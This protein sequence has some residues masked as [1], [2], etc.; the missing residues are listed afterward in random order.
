MVTVPDII[1]GRL[2]CCSKRSSANRCI[3]AI[4]VQRLSNEKDSRVITHWEGV[5][6]FH[7]NAQRTVHLGREKAKEE[8]G[9]PDLV[10]PFVERRVA[11]NINE[12]SHGQALSLND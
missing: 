10:F 1:F 11:V 8:D 2:E 7:F 12:R 9:R 4:F 5:C 3:S 6:H